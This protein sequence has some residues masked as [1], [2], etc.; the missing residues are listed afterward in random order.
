MEHFD[1]ATVQGS[2]HGVGFS[3]T[4][5]SEIELLTSQLKHYFP[6]MRLEVATKLPS[7]ELYNCYIKRLSGKDWD[8]AWW[9]MKQLCSRGWEPL[10]AASNVYGQ[11]TSTLF[12]YQFR[13]K[14]QRAKL[15]AKFANNGTC[16]NR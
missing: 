5:S 10:G 4:D 14:S 1:F 7:G 8:A 3:C 15:S 16:T 13:R 9:I 6:Q 12:V 2:S 11:Q